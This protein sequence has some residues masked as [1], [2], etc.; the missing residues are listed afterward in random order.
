MGDADELCLIL[1]TEMLSTATLKVILNL[2]QH[3]QHV[4]NYRLLAASSFKI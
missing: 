4:T 1:S 2:L 3:V